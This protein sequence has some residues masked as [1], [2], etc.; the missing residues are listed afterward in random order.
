MAADPTAAERKRRERERR[1][2][3]LVQVVEEVPADRA[4]DLRKVAAE[5]R[6]DA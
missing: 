5:M 1:K 4:D 6:G 2:R 3:G